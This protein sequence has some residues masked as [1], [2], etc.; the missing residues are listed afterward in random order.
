M[1]K[2]LFFGLKVFN[3]VV[4]YEL[5]W[6][7]GIG[8][9]LIIDEI[10]MMYDDLRVVMVEYFGEDGNDVRFFYGG[11]MKLVNVVEILVVVNVNGGLVGG[12][13]LKV[14]DFFEIILVV[15]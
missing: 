3:I 10:V 6:V 8:R 7:I 5:V 13:S 15:K 9:M 2:F 1:V 12:V 11:F 14:K 4:V